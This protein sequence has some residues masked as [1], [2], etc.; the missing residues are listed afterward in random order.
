MEAGIKQ[1]L[2]SACLIFERALDR[3]GFSI[4]AE[5]VAELAGRIH[6]HI[7]PDGKFPLVYGNFFLDHGQVEDLRAWINDGGRHF[8]FRLG[9]DHQA[10]RLV[11]LCSRRINVYVRRQAHVG[12]YGDQVA[13]RSGAIG[14]SHGKLQ[15]RS[16]DRIA[17]FFA[18][19]PGKFSPERYFR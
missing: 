12:A 16:V 18:E 14:E 8:E 6:F 13:G 10:N 11:A 15:V 17:D 19:V 3:D 9:V 7:L 5:R 4:G 1:I 2:L